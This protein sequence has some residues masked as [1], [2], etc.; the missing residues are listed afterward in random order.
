[1]YLILFTR[2]SWNDPRFGE[3]NRGSLYYDPSTRSSGSPVPL[4]STI[5]VRSLLRT[6]WG[7]RG[8]S[9]SARGRVRATQAAIFFHAATALQTRGIE[10]RASIQ[11]LLFN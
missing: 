4:R 8:A 1:M 6:G 9:G 7:P 10:R 5:K 2:L 3:G 11:V